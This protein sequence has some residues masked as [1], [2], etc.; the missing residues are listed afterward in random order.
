MGWS[1]V[2]QAVLAQFFAEPAMLQIVIALVLAFCGLTIIVGLRHVF[3][4]AA[5]APD[6]AAS[7]PPPASAQPSKQEPVMAP[8][9]SAAPLKAE[10]ALA[11]PPEPRQAVVPAGRKILP[12]GLRPAAA[13]ASAKAKPV[14]RRTQAAKPQA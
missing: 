10:A 13:L 2:W 12:P 11:V 4:P 9:L 3:A 7:L 14:F 5:P 1:G 8:V 6:E